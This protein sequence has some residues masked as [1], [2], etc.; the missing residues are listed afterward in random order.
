LSPSENEGIHEDTGNGPVDFK[1]S[2]GFSGRVLVEI[3]L[4]TNSKILSGYSKQL[5]AYKK[6]EQALIGYYVVI[7]V[8]GMGRKDRQLLATKNA[9]ARAVSGRVESVSVPNALKM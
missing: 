8:G 2:I 1:M 5:E 3:K 6:A 9:A 7:D 4:S